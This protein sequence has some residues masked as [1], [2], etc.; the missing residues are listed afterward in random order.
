MK[1]QEYQNNWKLMYYLWGFLLGFDSAIYVIW[2]F[3]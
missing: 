1:E 2:S 3:T